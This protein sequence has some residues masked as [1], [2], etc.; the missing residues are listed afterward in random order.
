MVRV[1]YTHTRA[2]ITV[3]VVVQSLTGL[4]E[5]DYGG[6]L[7]EA[8]YR[9]ERYPDDN[10]VRTAYGWLL[11]PVLVRAG[12]GVQVGYAVSASHADSS[13]FVLTDPMQ[14]YPPDDPRFSTAGRYVP[15]HTPDQAV[16]HSVI[17]AATL[18][19]KHGATFHLDGS[20]GLRATD[21]A[22]FFFVSDTQIVPSTYARTFSTWNVR[23]SLDVTLRDRLTLTPAGDIGRTAFYSWAGAT[24]KLTYRFKPAPVRRA[25]TP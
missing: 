18:G 1:P 3:P 24:L 11:A 19:P 8:A 10:G 20:Y 23:A 9:L 5:W 17:A 25:A 15:Y 13:R 7:A 6:W 12:K 14:P 16:T 21:R 22:P 4:V 2:S